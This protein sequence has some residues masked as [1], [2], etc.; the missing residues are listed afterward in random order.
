[1]SANP[2]V[3][4]VALRAGVRLVVSEADYL[5]GAGAVTLVV[6]GVDRIFRYAGEDW[7]ELHARQMMSGGAS[8]ARVVSVR[9][10]A[11]RAAV[12]QH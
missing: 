1:V 11:L 5:Y 8:I 6:G 12:R 3:G 9:V 4:G 7:V 2:V 10:G